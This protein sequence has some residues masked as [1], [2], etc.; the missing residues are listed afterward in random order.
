MKMTLSRAEA[1]KYLRQGMTALKM[2]ETD[3]K[4]RFVPLEGDDFEIVIDGVEPLPLIAVTAIGHEISPRVRHEG[5]TL[6]E[7]HATD[8]EIKALVRES[9]ALEGQL[10]T[11]GR[12]DNGHVR[13]GRTLEELGASDWRDELPR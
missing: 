2:P 1:L 8:E 9:H 12:G 10:P 7:R 13:V 3:D 6:P 11:P 4:I 5:P